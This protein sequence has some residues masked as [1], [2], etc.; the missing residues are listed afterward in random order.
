[1]ALVLAESRVRASGAV[2]GYDVRGEFA[3]NA[4]SPSI[5]GT[6][7]KLLRSYVRGVQQDVGASYALAN[8]R[9]N[10]TMTYA[11]R[12][13]YLNAF[14]EGARPH[15][16][17]VNAPLPSNVRVATGF[18]SRGSRGARVGEIWSDT[19]SDDGHF[20]IFIKPTLVGTAR[21][22]DVLTHEL[23]HAAVGLD[24]G[25]NQHFKRVSASL[26][27]T[28]K[29]TTPVAGSAWYTWA[30]PIIESL[31]EMPYGALS[32]D[33][34]SARA[35]QVTSLLKVEC[36]VCG[37]LARVTRKHIAPHSHLNCPVPDCLGELRC[38]EA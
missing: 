33:Q 13:E 11:T 28:G 7:L 26:G 3:A 8:Y 2:Y 14:I 21:I 32:G 15:F 22:C 36:P 24:K 4:A 17:R 18:T 29:A 38:E 23:I 20:E 30:L 9:G 27:L 19:S 10:R 1:M 35:K 6:D 5:T 16:E 25:H 12:E 37:F 31:G 34:S